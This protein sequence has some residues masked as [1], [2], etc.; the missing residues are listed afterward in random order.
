MLTLK[1]PTLGNQTQSRTALALFAATLLV[2]SVTEA[3]A[4]SHRYHHHGYRHHHPASDSPGGSW[5]WRT[6]KAT[7]AA[8]SE[9]GPT[10]SRMAFFYGNEPGSKTASGQRF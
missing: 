8:S 6:A 9:S 2:G 10:V 1:N 7:T 4:K 5:D 3:L